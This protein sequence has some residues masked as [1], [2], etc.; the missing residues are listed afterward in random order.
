[1]DRTSNEGLP[2]IIVTQIRIITKDDPSPFLI[3][4]EGASYLNAAFV[5]L[6]SKLIK[7]FA[8]FYFAN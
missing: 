1:M 6:E 8:L 7:F 5:T 4:A 3:A 2:V